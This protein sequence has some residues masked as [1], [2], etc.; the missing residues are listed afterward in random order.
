MTLL[1]FC[2]S[3][4]NSKLFDPSFFMWPSI[5]WFLFLWML[6]DIPLYSRNVL[7]IHYVYLGIDLMPKSLIW[8]LHEKKDG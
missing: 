3:M 2:V 8:T 7:N 5:F 1:A 4:E 6:T